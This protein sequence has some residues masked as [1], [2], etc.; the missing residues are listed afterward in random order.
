MT[1]KYTEIRRKDYHKFN[2]KDYLVMYKDNMHF[3][4][5]MPTDL[6]CIMY[7]EYAGKNESFDKPGEFVDSYYSCHSEYY[8]LSEEDLANKAWE[9][10][11]VDDIQ[12]AFNVSKYNR[13]LSKFVER[14][15][16]HRHYRIFGE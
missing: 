10:R 1:E 6:I 2:D 5:Y 14:D 15:P 16:E 9:E 13:P 8:L 7:C 4:S 12:T 11:A 3:A